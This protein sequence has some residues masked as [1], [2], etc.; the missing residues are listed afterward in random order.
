MSDCI[1]TTHARDE[2]GYGMCFVMRFGKRIKKTSVLAWVDANG[3]LPGPGMQINHHCDNPPCENVEHLYEGTQVENVRDMMRRGRHGNTKKT[4]CPY[5]HE[6]TAENTYIWNG[7]RN[8]RICINRRTNK[9]YHA[10]K[11]ARA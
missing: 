11:A 2:H 4:H 5:G 8:C 1:E 9:Y 7:R 6:Y 3:R 10:Q